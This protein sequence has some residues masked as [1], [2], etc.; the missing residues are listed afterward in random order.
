MKNFKLVLGTCLLT[1]L[2]A[3]TQL[4][5]NL[6]AAAGEAKLV[7]SSPA[8]GASISSAPSVATIT[9]SSSIGDVGNSVSVTAPNGERVDDGS[10]QIADTQILVGLKPL[11]VSGDYS[12]EYEVDT[13]EGETL[14]GQYKFTFVSPAVLESP[15]PEDIEAPTPDLNKETKSSKVTDFFMIGLLVL[16]ILVLVLIS[17]SLRKPKKKKRKK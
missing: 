17:R 5:P 8:S 11:S 12:V 13:T 2:I 10:L 6:A 14:S 3:L 1:A 4:N 15:K 16:S 9:F 7:S